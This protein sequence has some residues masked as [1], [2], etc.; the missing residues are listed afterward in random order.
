MLAYLLVFSSHFCSFWLVSLI[1]IG[2]WVYVFYCC[3][4]SA[5][6]GSLT[7]H[8]QKWHEPTLKQYTL[9]L[10]KQETL[11]SNAPKL[12][13][14]SRPYHLLDRL[15][16]FGSSD[17]PFPLDSDKTWREQNSAIKKC[18]NVYRHRHYNSFQVE[19]CWWEEFK[20]LLQTFYCVLTWKIVSHILA[21]A[22][23]NVHTPKIHT[24]KRFIV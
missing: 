6:N 16:P 2:L 19:N 21:V 8:S 22:K 10:C 23:M 17:V 12:N 4:S 18:W 1:W 20:E 13:Q 7:A 5:C 24:F 3:K 15:L 14:C 9:S 11:L